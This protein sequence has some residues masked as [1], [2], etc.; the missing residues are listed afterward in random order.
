MTGS[1][2]EPEFSL[3]AVKDRSRWLSR[4]ACDVNSQA[5]E[6]GILLK[7][8]SLIPDPNRW[9]VEFGAWDGKYVSNTFNLVGNHGYSTVLIEGD[10]QKYR[11]L[12]SEYPYKDRAV[13]VHA[14]VGWSSQDNLDA[15]L[16]PHAIPS[17]PDLVSI[18]VD[19]NDYHIWSAMNVTRPKLLLIEYNPTMANTVEFVQAADPRLNQG[20]SPASLVELGKRKSYELIAATRLNLLFVDA[21]YYPLFGIPDNSLEA[22]R[23]DPPD[24][25][26]SGYDGT[27]FVQGAVGARWHR[28]WLA[29]EDIQV[30]PRCF[31]R[32]P[33]L[34][35][36]LER[37]AL[38][39]YQRL[40]GD[41]AAAR[42][43]EPNYMAAERRRHHS[44]RS[45]HS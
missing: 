3:R 34:Y 31:R 6:D 16:A 7:A 39:C 38:A 40:R 8:L 1:R 25:V 30:L 13:F 28:M 15:I 2:P 44:R 5:G 11:H 32:Y 29:Q 24:H 10:E 14:Y 21:K 27:I 42:V 36:R 22:L 43:P 26:F 18:D 33:P 37:F 4:F 20:N 9:S 45:R 17:D 12:C 41:S 35:N 19:G 23:D